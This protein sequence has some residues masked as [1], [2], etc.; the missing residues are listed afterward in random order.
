MSTKKPSEFDV[1][2]D[3]ASQAERL[4]EEAKRFLAQVIEK[5]ADMDARQSVKCG[6]AEDWKEER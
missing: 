4:S 5:L 2:F 6:P 3:L 1:V